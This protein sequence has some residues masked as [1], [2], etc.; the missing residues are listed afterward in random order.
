MSI[1][2][3]YRRFRAWQVKPFRYEDAVEPHTCTNCGRSYGGDFCP[4]CGQKNDVGRV[5]WKSVGQEL[6]KIWGME[7]R[8]LLSSI[9]QLL[10]RPGYLIGDYI[11]GRRQV[12]YSPV[13]MLFVMAVI[14]SVIL[15]L[16]GIQVVKIDDV[17]TS[18]YDALG[19]AAIWMVNHL[20]W[21]MLIITAFLILPTWLLFRY[22]PRHPR[23]TL[24]EGIYI[25]LF[26][27]T[28]V[29]LFFVLAEAFAG[30][31]MWLVPVYYFIAFRQLFGYGVWGT[32]WR[33]V[34][35]WSISL[36]LALL[37]SVEFLYITGQK[38][39]ETDP[40]NTYTLGFAALLVIC[41][42]ILFFGYWIGKH[43]AAKRHQALAETGQ[44]RPVE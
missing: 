30:W 44:G 8:S 41:L 13:S 42:G 28:L 33:T 5:S 39:S 37:L 29:L 27:S 24:P 6:I 15:R 31:L 14:V 26:M 32:L 23:H 10:G 19:N 16:A 4:V 35:T 11:S 34:M 38:P 40:A 1:K 43:R 2:D 12:C 22:A 7:S 21:G 36:L 25:Q 17:E 20:G 18:D 3:Q 9:L